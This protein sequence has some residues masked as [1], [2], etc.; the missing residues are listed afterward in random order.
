MLVCPW[1]SDGPGISGAGLSPGAGGG[2]G[3]TAPT[4]FTTVFAAGIDAPASPRQSDRERLSGLRLP[5]IVPPA[6]WRQK[7]EK[8]GPPVLP[9]S[10][11]GSA[12]AGQSA[13]G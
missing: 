2:P 1:R 8:Q 6:G 3:P 4:D 5:G 12:A 11:W 10:A 13:A 7:G 9:H